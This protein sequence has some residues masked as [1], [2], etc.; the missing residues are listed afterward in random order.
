MRCG[1]NPYIATACRSAKCLH[2]IRGDI[3]T[4]T[5]PLAWTIGMKKGQSNKKVKMVKAIMYATQTFY[6]FMLM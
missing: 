4:E 2:S 1:K 5:T 6:A 3:G